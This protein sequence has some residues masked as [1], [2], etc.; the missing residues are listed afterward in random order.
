MI[1]TAATSREVAERALQG[2]QT[3]GI[4]DGSGRTAVLTPAT[5]RTRGGGERPALVVTPIEE[6]AG[7]R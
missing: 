6:G 7:P 1:V 4:R 3:A 2:P 5:V